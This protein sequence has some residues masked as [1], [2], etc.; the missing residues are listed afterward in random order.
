[1][2]DFRNAKRSNSYFFFSSTRVRC[3]KRRRGM[4]VS[5]FVQDMVKMF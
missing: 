4:D 1:M 5:E 2:N 3:D